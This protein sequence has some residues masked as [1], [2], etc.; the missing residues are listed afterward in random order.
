M[1]A[2]NP[3]SSGS[4]GV[5]K[6]DM[7]LGPDTDGTAL[8]LYRQNIELLYQLEFAPEAAARFLSHAVTYQ[9]PHAVLASVESVAQTLSRGPA[10][11]AR[12]GDQFVLYAQ[13]EGRARCRTMRGATR[14]IRPGD[15]VIIDYSREI[16][17]RATD[18]AHH[19]PDGARATWCRRCFSRRRST[20][21]SFRPRAAPGG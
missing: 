19:V 8:A 3:A 17:S 10:E 5:P 11:I 13:V 21:R 12:G 7:R 15:V 20:A 6:F 18:F 14:K 4:T 2:D 1:N 9:L 16:V